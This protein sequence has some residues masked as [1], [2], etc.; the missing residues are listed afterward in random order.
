MVYNEIEGPLIMSFNSRRPE[1]SGPE[2]SPGRATLAS[3]VRAEVECYSGYR[4]EETPRAVTLG[5]KRLDISEVLSRKR[6]R[7]NATGRTVEIFLCRLGDGRR[8]SL[9]RSDDGSWRARGFAGPVSR[10]GPD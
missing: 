5:R 7:D 3:W 8:V 9:E 6:L 2:E 10:V 1:S 4:A